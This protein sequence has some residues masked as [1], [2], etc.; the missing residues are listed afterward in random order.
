MKAFLDLIVYRR[1]IRKLNIHLSEKVS[2]LRKLILLSLFF[3][4]QIP[5]VIHF[6][7]FSPETTLKS[8]YNIVY[9]ML[10]QRADIVIVI[11]ELWCVEV[12]DFFKVHSIESTQLKKIYNPVAG[13]VESFKSAPKKRILFMGTLSERKGYKDL[14]TAF[15]SIAPH[16]RDGWTLV[17]CGDGSLIEANTIILKLGL[18][19]CVELKG[20]V[21]DHMKYKELQDASMFVLPSYKE[22]LPMALLEAIGFNLPCISSD[23]PG[24]H[25]LKDVVIQKTFV[26]GD[27]EHLADLITQQIYEIEYGNYDGGEAHELP[28]KFKYQTFEREMIK[29]YEQ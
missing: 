1:R 25:E 26:P 27:T 29:I 20:W 15:S 6:H 11:S 16:K 10:F 17:L 5:V 18:S 22:G 21:D 13:P 19:D 8:R 12:E 14:I 23:L 7:A 9:R 24:I 2:A 28:E 3:K 4:G